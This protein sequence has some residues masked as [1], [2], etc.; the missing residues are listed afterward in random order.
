[1]GNS[2]L[3]SRSQSK[4]NEEVNYYP[5]DLTVV[6]TKEKTNSICKHTLSW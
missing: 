1:M 2:W 5:V 4:L 6:V 3:R